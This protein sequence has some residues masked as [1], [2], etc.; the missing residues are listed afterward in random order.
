MTSAGSSREHRDRFGGVTESEIERLAEVST[1]LR[2]E[3]ELAFYGAIDFIP[4]DEYTRKHAQQALDDATWVVSVA[5]SVILIRIVILRQQIRTLRSTSRCPTPPDPA[6]P[7]PRRPTC[8]AC[9]VVISC[10]H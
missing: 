7:N 6:P 2:K 9:R 5:G 10:L 4:T 3:R 8:F 1:A